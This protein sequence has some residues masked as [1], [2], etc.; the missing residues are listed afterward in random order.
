M[1]R[2][3]K[4]VTHMSP[5]ALAMASAPGPAT[6]D[7]HDPIPI[8]VD[9][10]QRVVLLLRHPHHSVWACRGLGR[11]PRDGERCD[12]LL[13]GR[14]EAD[15]EPVGGR[16]PER[17]GDGR[18]KAGPVVTD[19]RPRQRS[20]PRIQPAK[21]RTVPP[22]CD[23]EGAARLREA[24]GIPPD[25]VH[26]RHP[27]PARVDPCDRPAFVCRHP[28]TPE[29]GGDV[30]RPGRHGNPPD[31]ASSSRID[32]IEHVRHVAGDPH[33]ACGDDERTDPP[34]RP[35]CERRHD[36]FEGRS[37]LGARCRRQRPRPSR[38]LTPHRT[39]RRQSRPVRPAEEWPRPPPC[40]PGPPRRPSESGQDASSELHP[41]A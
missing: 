36:C 34:A 7:V 25:G 14:I 19:R 9:A 2:P 20:A 8:R 31:D 40:R 13:R 10:G 3:A 4:L 16:R 38:N 23:P 6:G 39:A 26:T 41:A 15:R 30:R 5:P 29:R 21:R 24:G 35:G 12:D 1:S 18:E 11:G 27:V 17:A 22:E 32:A 28:E 33:G 37:A